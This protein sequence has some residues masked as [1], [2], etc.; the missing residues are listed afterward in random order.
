LLD[1]EHEV[2]SLNTF[3]RLLMVFIC[4][5]VIQT[6]PNSQLNKMCFLRRVCAKVVGLFSGRSSRR[7]IQLEEAGATPGSSISSS[8]ARWEQEAEHYTSNPD[9]PIYSANGGVNFSST[10]DIRAYFED[11]LESL[12][13]V[14]CFH[15]PNHRFNP[16][17]PT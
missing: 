9:V 3:P 4:L 13:S 5:L 14:V 17:S 15:A 2:W 6:C 16:M 1:H 7:Q 12:C 11:D 8:D 10:T